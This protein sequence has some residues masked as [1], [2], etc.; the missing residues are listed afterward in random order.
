MLKENQFELFLEFIGYFK[1]FHQNLIF[2][3]IF[4]AHLFDDEFR[5]TF[6]HELL[7][8]KLMAA[9]HPVQKSQVFG[10][11]IGLF[12]SIC[13][14]RQDRLSLRNYHETYPAGTLGRAIELKEVRLKGF[15][16]Y[17]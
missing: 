12:S 8:S 2:Y 6:Y 14:I 17:F 1:V 4:F 5:V 11:I 3:L 16:Y 13:T 7:D 10:L 9:S 15:Y